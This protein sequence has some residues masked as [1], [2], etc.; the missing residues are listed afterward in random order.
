MDMVI[1]FASVHYHCLADK[2]SSPDSSSPTVDWSHIQGLFERAK[3]DVLVLLDC[4]AAASSAPR[5][6]DAVIET[7]AACGF[8][9]KAPPPGEHSFTTSLIEVLEDWINAP[10]S[11]SLC[12]TVRF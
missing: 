9:G 3:S 2:L 7:I 12:Y 6:R 10:F 8:E 4:C 11:Q 1:M 5:R